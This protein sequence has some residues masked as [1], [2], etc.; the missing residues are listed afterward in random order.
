MLVVMGPTASGKT[1]FAV[2]VARKINSLCKDGE[3]PFTECH[4]ISADSRQ[5]YRGMDIG[6]GK[7]IAEYGK[8][9]YHLIDIA[10]AGEKYD[11]FRYKKDFQKVY[12]ELK[13]KN[14]FPILC[15]GSGL[16]IEAVC[17]DY[18]LKEV[19]PDPE[20]RKE[21]E[22]KSMEELVSMLTGLKARHGTEPHNNTDFD[23]KKRVIRAIEIER[24]YDSI[25]Q[26]E[27][28]FEGPKR[29]H[30]LALNPDRELR[31]QKIDR[32]LDERLK[33]GMVDEVK[34]L[35]DKGIKPEDL[36]YYGLEYKFLTQYITGEISYEWMKEHLAIAIH[37]FAKRQMTWLRGMERRGIKIEWIKV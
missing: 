33:N 32:R 36:I 21:L 27:E 29:V 22:Q 6:T 9:P 3:L 25:P 7:D 35:M 14:I 24:A 16:Y 10:E 4:I 28:S 30:Y 2:K 1:A 18:D 5:V 15:G 19:A 13:K 11:L 31:N 34:T 26:R 23:T 17:K 12:S 8:I 37:Q 20:L